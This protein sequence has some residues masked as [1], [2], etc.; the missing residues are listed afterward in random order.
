MY[1]HMDGK[2]FECFYTLSHNSVKNCDVT[3]FK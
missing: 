3:Q 2:K 1:K